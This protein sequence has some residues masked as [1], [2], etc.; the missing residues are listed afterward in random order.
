[1]GSF[2]LASLATRAVF[3][4][5]T[6]TRPTTTTTSR[7]TISHPVV[8]V[9]LVPHTWHHLH[10]LLCVADPTPFRITRATQVSNL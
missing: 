1:M 5:N 8:D 9:L 7:I 4:S 10:Q 6:T 3:V 2:R